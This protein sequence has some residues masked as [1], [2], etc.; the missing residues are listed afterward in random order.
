VLEVNGEPVLTKNDFLGRSA[1]HLGFTYARFVI[2]LLLNVPSFRDYTARVGGALTS[3]AA[4]TDLMVAALAQKRA[5]RPSERP[6][7]PQRAPIRRMPFPMPS[8]RRR[9]AIRR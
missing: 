1:K 6:A 3:Y 8:Y 2:G 9:G 5:T 7:S 4:A